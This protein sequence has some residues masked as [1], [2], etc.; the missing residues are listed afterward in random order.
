MQR[1]VKSAQ[2]LGEQRSRPVRDRQPYVTRRLASFG[3][4]LRRLVLGE[5]EGGRPERG[6][7]ANSSPGLDT[8]LK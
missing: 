3:D 1:L 2:M 5:R 4:D 6:A 7:S 8:F